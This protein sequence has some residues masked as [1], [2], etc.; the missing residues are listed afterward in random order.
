MGAALKPLFHFCSPTID[1][2]Q[3]EGE[4]E[5]TKT[6]K[7]KVVKEST[8]QKWG[9][10]YPW[11]VWTTKKAESGNHRAKCRVCMDHNPDKHEF[12]MVDGD[13]AAVQ[14]ANDL[15]RHQEGPHHVLAVKR[16]LNKSGGGGGIASGMTGL[17]MHARQGALEVIP[18]MMRCALWL[19]IEGMPGSKFPSLLALCKMVGIHAIKHKYNNY[20][21]FW[22][23]MYAISELALCS[24]LDAVNKSPYF[25]LLCDGSMDITCQ[26]CHNVHPLP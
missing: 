14:D 19:M 7:K 21:Y 16:S 2:T 11:L 5:H 8:R 1:L 3:E 10:Q 20:K 17:A 24:V 23:C 18:T 26:K 15:K 25:S 6:R 9:E 22:S 4:Q 13:G 12:G